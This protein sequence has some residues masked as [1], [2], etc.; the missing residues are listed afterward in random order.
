MGI[1]ENVYA[2]N[3]G[4]GEGM[5][6]EEVLDGNSRQP[7]TQAPTAHAKFKSVDALAIAYGALEA[8][9][10]RRSQRI[11]EL[12]KTVE[13]LKA[14]LSRAEAS[15]AEK[16]RKNAEARRAAAKKFD[17]FVEELGKAEEVGKPNV[18]EE[19]IPLKTEGEEAVT[20]GAENVAQVTEKTLEV[21]EVQT[22]ASEGIS[23][24]ET[25]VGEKEKTSVVAENAELSS[26]ELYARASRDENVRLKII[27][28]YLHSVG[29]NSPPLTAG[30]VGTLTTPTA[31]AKTIVDAGNLALQFFKKP[32]DV[33]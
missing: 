28:E 12:E 15:G 31:K 25:L 21:D 9:F 3:F 20:K 4:A 2:E 1:E 32:F 30:G 8:E 33:N 29:R 27:G 7:A 6:Q 14:D 5:K 19:D 23:A 24:K 11:K 26:E 16:L 13:N 10:T 17:A 22:M 18:C